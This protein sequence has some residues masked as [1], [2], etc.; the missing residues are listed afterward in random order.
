MNEYGNKKILITGAMGK[1]GLA[2]LRLALRL[3]AKVGISDR[4]TSPLPE[5]LRDKGIQDLRPDESPAV[6]QW[7]P[8]LII[9]AP[10]VPLRNEIFLKAR[11]RGIPVHG[12]HDFA[13]GVFRSRN[14]EKFFT[15]GV[16]GTDGKSTTVT[17]IFSLLRTL[18]PDTNPILCGNIGFP[19][20]DIADLPAGKDPILVAELSSYQLEPVRCFAPDVSAILNLAQDHLDRYHDMEDY[21]RA[22]LNLIRFQGPEDIFLAPSYILKKAKEF[23]K[24]LGKDPVRTMD[25]EDPSGGI[26]E[27]DGRILFRGEDLLSAS[28]FGLEGS[29]NLANL[30]VTLRILF[31]FAEKTGRTIDRNNLVR[32]IGEL[33]GLPHRM[34]LLGEKRGIRFINDSKATTVQSVE[35]ALR[36]YRGRNVFLLIGGRQKGADYTILGGREGVSYFPYGEAGPLIARALGV[37]QSYPGMA[38]AFRAAVEQ[39]SGSTNPILLLSPGCSSFDEFRSF[40][41]RGEAFRSLVEGLSS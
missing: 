39:A 38:D 12:E 17:L 40:E 28:E 18:F 9:T 37:D 14:P 25:L 34:E 32:A 29:H 2:A 6:L 4:N 3:G 35:S 11:E 7:D 16:T 13:F 23:E 22:K 21:L 36:S 31:A 20:S 15:I 27:R 33:K 19:L 10:G 26:L 5:D 8:D 1:S 24:E 41:E 30:D